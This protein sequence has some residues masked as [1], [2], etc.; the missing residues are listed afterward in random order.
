[1]TVESRHL[2]FHGGCHGGAI[3]ALADTAFGFASNSYGQVA[4]GIDAHVTFQVG[5]R[6]GDRLVARAAEVRR[7]R[8]IGVYEVDVACAHVDG[9]EELVSRFTGTVYIR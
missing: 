1:M 5:V 7:S 9:R 6:A 4:V 8:R 2:N 3:F